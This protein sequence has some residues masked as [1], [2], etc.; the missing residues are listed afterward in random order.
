M[1]CENCGEKIDQDFL[2]ILVDD[3]LSEGK[4][5]QSIEVVYCP[6]CQ[7]DGS[8]MWSVKHSEESDG[9]EED[10]EEILEAL[11]AMAEEEAEESGILGLLARVVNTL[12]RVEKLLESIEVVDDEEETGEQE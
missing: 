4:D 12:E 2:K 8:E 9:D 7:P 3:T 1:D 5:L 11:A 6:E 10:D